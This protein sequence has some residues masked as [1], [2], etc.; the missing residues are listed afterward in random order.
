[1]KKLLQMI[2]IS[3][4]MILC[5]SAVA[6]TDSGTADTSCKHDYAETVI[7]AT[8]ES[9]GY[10]E[11]VCKKCGDKYEGNETP[12]LGHNLTEWAE[13]T[14]ATCTEAQVLERHCQRSGCDY[15]E[16]KEGTIKALGHNIVWTETKAPTCS[17][18]GLKDGACDRAGCNYTVKDEIVKKLAHHYVEV[19]DDEKAKPAT[20]TE[21]GLK[22]EVCDR[23]G[24]GDRKETVLF[25]FSH[26]DDGT[27]E[28]VTAPTCTEQGYT[29][30]RCSVCK[31]DYVEDYTDALGHDMQESQ[32]VSVSCLTDGYELWACARSG[33]DY[34]EKRNE[35]EKI[36]HV[37]NEEGA[38]Q[39]GCGKTLADKIT[40]AN[41]KYAV[42]YNEETGRLKMEGD[43]PG[44]QQVQQKVKIP[45]ELFAKMKNEGKVQFAVTMYRWNGTT[46]IFGL[47]LTSEGT[48]SEWKYSAWNVDSYTTGIME[49]TDEML[50]DGFEFWALYADCTQRNPAYGATVKC[51]GFDLDIEFIKPFDINDKSM[52]LSSEFASTTYSE[53]KAKWII[54]DATIQDQEDVQKNITIKADVFKALKETYGSFKIKLSTKDAG[55]YP[56]YGIKDADV[57]WRNYKYDNITLESNEYA[58]TEDMLANGYSF[59]VL[60]ADA[61]K[62]NHNEGKPEVDGFEMEIEFVKPFDIND[63]TMWLTSG[64][65]SMTY[66]EEKDMW[67]INN[68]DPGSDMIQKSITIKAEVFKALPTDVTSFK[69]MM[70]KQG[71]GQKPQFGIL[72]GAWTFAHAHNDPLVV[73]IEITDDMRA[74][75]FTF[76][77][78]Y[79]DDVQREPETYSGTEIVTGFDMKIEFVST[80]TLNA[81]NTTYVKDG[82]VAYDG[83]VFIF[84]VES[85]EG[86]NTNGG[87]YFTIGSYGVYFRGNAFRPATFNG[88]N[89]AAVSHSGQGSL[90]ISDFKKGVQ[91]GISVAIKDENTVTVTVYVNGDKNCEQDIA[92]VSGE[93]ESSTATARVE[94]NATDVTK[95]VLIV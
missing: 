48:G 74:N 31:Q 81:D 88:T 23:E 17:E 34:T 79:L 59:T 4:M 35:Q 42:T 77:A 53:E 61:N 76:T 6:C 19:P 67:V 90:D 78:L 40:W 13:K 39:S 20:C 95:L 18:T 56:I 94:I 41:T 62:R 8:C 38:C 91:I 83:T 16:T 10:T 57:D 27:K 85:A 15:S 69:L 82:K 43:D 68:G 52:W 21:N 51:T 73:T 36:D 54:T 7:E 49:I 80:I 72:S 22:V 12:A 86:P 25:A 44:D 60:Y 50:T 93:I 14:A 37:F 5:V 32:S 26:T 1:M 58:I 9:G 33:C 11:F 64:F 46:P 45:A 75:G 29:T 24:C 70:Y 47:N 3:A 65:A 71:E 89:A 63:K 2:L 84:N 66:S 55:A 87:V 30:R 92:R 28:E